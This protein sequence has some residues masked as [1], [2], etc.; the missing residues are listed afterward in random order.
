MDTQTRM[1]WIQ[2]L[3]LEPLYKFELIGL[4][5]GLAVYNGLTLPVTFPLA[6]YSQLVGMPVSTIPMIE[7]GWPELAKGLKALQDWTDGDVAGVFL[8]TYTFSLDVFGSNIDVDMDARRRRARRSKL[9]KDKSNATSSDNLK[10][11]RT[12]NVADAEPDAG[13]SSSEAAPFFEASSSRTLIASRF[14]DR[15]GQNGH[16]TSPPDRMPVA[17]DEG[18]GSA[19]VLN[20]RPDSPTPSTPMVTNANRKQ[21]VDDYIRHLTYTSIAPQLD[22]FSS[23]FRRCLNRKS[24]SIFDPVTL[25]ALVEGH[26]NIDTKKL[27]A[28]ATYEGG[29]DKH[30]YAIRDFWEIVH[31]WGDAGEAGRDKVRRLLEF[32]TASDRLPVGGVERITFM[33]QK[34]GVGDERLPTSLTCFGRLLLPQYSNIDPMRRGLERAIEEAKGFGVA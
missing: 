28:I 7:D 6:L 11:S 15:K 4:L 31:G 26:E 25:Q 13:Y 14:E 24:L 34:N 27:Q 33:V 19:H 32:V 20:H 12:S 22:A 5:V 23:G 10:N 16:Y 18:E 8:R 2:P 30:H 21:Y 17:E 9:S 3:S 1:S 29:Y